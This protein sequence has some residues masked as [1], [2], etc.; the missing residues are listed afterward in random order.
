VTPRKTR[1]QVPTWVADSIRDKRKKLLYGTYNCPKCRMPK[2]R[3]L[4]NKEKRE[5]VAV[6]DCGLEH[7]LKYVGAFERVDYYNNL[8][9][10]FYKTK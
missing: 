9:D 8:M 5:V 2:L 10:Q 6:C 3:I 4:V 7:P 1:Y